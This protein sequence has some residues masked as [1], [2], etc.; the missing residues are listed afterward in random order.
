[1]YH[2]FCQA[3]KCGVL[4]CHL[5]PVHLASIYFAVIQ[6]LP[7]I[8]TNT[9]IFQIHIMPVLVDEY[10][11]QIDRSLKV[12]LGIFLSLTII[13]SQTQ[14]NWKYSNVLF[15]ISFFLWYCFIHFCIQVTHNKVLSGQQKR[16][17][18]FDKSKKT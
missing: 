3:V 5:Q 15:K 2:Y 9:Y 14:K 12:R 17:L 8:D 7:G 11:N 13:C 1:M 6:T 16:K 10:H 4:Q 18:G